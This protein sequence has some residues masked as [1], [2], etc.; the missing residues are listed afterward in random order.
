MFHPFILNLT[1]FTAPGIIAK[2]VSG[3]P[4]IDSLVA[5]LISQ[6]NASSR[7]PPRAGPSRS[8]IVGTGKLNHL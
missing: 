8:A 2:L 3:K 6:L 1:K 7:P 5:T 4:I